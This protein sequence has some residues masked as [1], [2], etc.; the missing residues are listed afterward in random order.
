MKFLIGT[1]IIT[2]VALLGSRI[3][4]L[5]R[6]F[7]L[8]VKNIFFTG[9]EYILLG[10]ALGV[11]GIGILDREMI[12]NFHPFLI[13]GLS[14]VGFLYGM[15]FEVKGLRT[16]PKRYFSITSIQA[17]ITFLFI[18]I[19]MFLFLYFVHGHAID[20]T[21]IISFI[22]GIAGLSTAQ[23]A[24]AIVNMNFRFRNQRLIDLLRYIA[25]VDGLFALLFFA[26][27]LAFTDPVSSSLASPLSVFRWVGLTIFTALIPT[28][29]FLLMNRTRYR[30][31]EFLLILTGIIAFTGG[32]SSY[33]SLSP[34]ISGLTAGIAIAN[35][36]K[37]RNRALKFLNNG[38]K[39]IY[40][41]MLIIL[42]AGWD[43]NTRVNLALVAIFI[44]FRSIG[45]VAGNLAG[46]KSFRSAFHIP[47]TIGF[48]LLSEGGLTFG[49]IIS[50][51]I[52]YPDYSA[53]V[54]PVILISAFIFEL[55]SPRL[56]LGFFRKTE[57]R[58]PDQGKGRT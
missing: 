4:F 21:V 58:K 47:G 45:K 56:I 5:R 26:L 8:G 17:L 39:P 55:I 1:A 33:L 24:L 54:I 36:C 48:S 37:Y 3:T 30:H 10:L 27:F 51:I 44:L 28:L 49:I 38:E 29:I 14:W 2:G 18:S 53:Q 57:N 40:I 31:E 15:Q 13:F 6:Q 11:S 50:F 9:I 7:G 32:I 16:L 42:G 12:G 34:I 41:I 52:L 23:S 35:T 19:S 25:G 43:L 22:L 46:V 20:R